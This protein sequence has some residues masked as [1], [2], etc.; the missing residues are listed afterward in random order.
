MSRASLIPAVLADQPEFE[1]FARRRRD[2][3]AAEA[4]AW[5]R[6]EAAIERRRQV[7]AAHQE[8][9]ESALVNGEDLPDGPALDPLPPYDR[10]L[11]DREFERI[12]ADERQ[13]LSTHAR[14]ILDRLEPQ[15]LTLT[16]DLD[17]LESEVRTKQQRLDEL[18]RVEKALRERAA[19]DPA[20]QPVSEDRPA[21]PEGRGMSVVGNLGTPGREIQAYLRGQRRAP[22]TR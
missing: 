17:Q 10:H 12:A 19:A 4:K 8:A 11:F 7:G 20:P 14:V 3:H 13:A 9:V 6:V 21:R 22:R 18:N 1:E 15:Q 16:A 2:L 5:D